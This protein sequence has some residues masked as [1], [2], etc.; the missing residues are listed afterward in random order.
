MLLRLADID[1]AYGGTLLNQREK[2]FCIDGVRVVGAVPVAEGFRVVKWGDDRFPA[3]EGAGGILAQAQASGLEAECIEYMESPHQRLADSRKT[4]DGF[5][6][7]HG[8]DDAGQCADH[9]GFLTRGNAAGGRKRR[10]QATVAGTACMRVENG[11]LALEPVDRSVNDGDFRKIPEVT[12][13]ESG[14]EIVTT[15]D[16]QVAAI[17]QTQGIVGSEP[18]LVGD[19]FDL[20][21]QILQ[22]R[23]CAMGFGRTDGGGPVDDLPVEVGRIDRIGIHD[24][25]FS[26][27]GSGEVVEHGR[28]ESTGT[29]HQDFCVSEPVLSSA[30]KFGQDHLS[31]VALAFRGCE[32]LLHGRVEIA[33]DRGIGQRRL[34]RWTGGGA[35][36]KVIPCLK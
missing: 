27:S 15:I 5:H 32:F 35:L 36:S 19:D 31:G 14:G 16:N 29:H 10:E 6:G 11:H 1:N 34:M 9:S 4:L 8:A 28:S 18:L 12:G 17:D 3:A 7:H 23:E 20:R 22:L 30:A 21:I 26:H 2:G 25:E 33:R 13:E 24:D